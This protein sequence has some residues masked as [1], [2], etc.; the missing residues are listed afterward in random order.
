[1]VS[2][3]AETF[4]FMKRDIASCRMPVNAAL[5]PPVGDCCPDGGHD[6]RAH[7]AGQTHAISDTERHIKLDPIYHRT[8]RAPPDD[9]SSPPKCNLPFTHQSRVMKHDHVTPQLPNVVLFSFF[10][11]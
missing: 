10:L 5:R 3:V 7:L 9:F 1:M 8:D 4:A 6:G 2:G 11:G